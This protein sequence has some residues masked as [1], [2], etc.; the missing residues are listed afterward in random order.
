MDNKN[1]VNF[2]FTRLNFALP[3]NQS[4]RDEAPECFQKLFKIKTRQLLFNYRVFALPTGLE[5]VF[6]LRKSLLYRSI[7]LN[8]ADFIVFIVPKFLLFATFSEKC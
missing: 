3:L 1:R 4:S 2:Q 8:F 6:S 7:C 5:P